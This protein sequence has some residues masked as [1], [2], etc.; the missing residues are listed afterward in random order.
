MVLVVLGVVLVVLVVI[1]V[2]VL[3]VLV[4]VLFMDE[5]LGPEHVHEQCSGQP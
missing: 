4:V 2:V 3:V 5:G 1:L